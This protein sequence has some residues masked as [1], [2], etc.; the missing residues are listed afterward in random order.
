MNGVKSVES[1]VVTF[2]HWMRIIELRDA[3]SKVSPSVKHFQK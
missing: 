3:N 2:T 1:T